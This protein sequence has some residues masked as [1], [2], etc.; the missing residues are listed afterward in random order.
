MKKASRTMIRG[1]QIAVVFSLIFTGCVSNKKVAYLQYEDELGNPA[2]IVTDSIIRKYESGE[3]RYRLQPNDV[4]NIKI[5]SLT[6]EEYNPFAIA[7]K[8]MSS[9]GVGV[10]NQSGNSALNVGYRIDPFGELNLPVIGTVVASGLTLSE[11]EEVIDEMAYEQLEDPVSKIVLMNFRFSIMGEVANEGL[12]T[13]SD[14]SLTM[15]Q[16]LAMA[17]GRDEFGDLSRVKVIRRIGDE[18]YVFYINLLD[19]TF[20]SSEF[21]FIHPNDVLYVPPLK[22]RTYFN[23]VAPNL[24]I[25]ASSLSLIASI[26]ALVSL[27]TTG[28]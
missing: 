19:E 9:G 28:N 23:Y 26:I 16:A 20:L 17:G 2:T 21:Y 11:L 24:S 6:P 13:S 12:F 15:M 22:S 7:D 1:L 3:L 8:Y 14:N 5:A 25:I 18:N 4:L 10:S 27:T